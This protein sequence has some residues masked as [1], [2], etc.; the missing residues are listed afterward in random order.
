[1]AISFKIINLCNYF[2]SWKYCEYLV[3]RECSTMKISNF[4]ALNMSKTG[5]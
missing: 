3:F 4:P 1:M 2:I 5:K